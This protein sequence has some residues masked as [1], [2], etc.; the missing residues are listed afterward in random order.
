LNDEYHTD[1]VYLNFIDWT[2]SVFTDQS[3][4]QAFPG[5]EAFT[6][7]ELIVSFYEN[8]AGWGVGESYAAS[9]KGTLTSVEVVS[10]VPVPPAVWLF[11]SGLIG[12][13]S[14]S[15]RKKKPVIN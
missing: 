11:F 8:G 14:F 9:L 2:H 1:Q 5:L 4:P 10:H 3:L 13:L 15:W 7:S 6:T 12:L